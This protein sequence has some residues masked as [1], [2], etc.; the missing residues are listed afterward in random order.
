VRILRLD[1]ADDAAVRA[2]CEVTEA[3]RRADDPFEPPRSAAV[4]HA[5]LGTHWSG[6]PVEAWYV[7]GE[8]DG[9]S[10]WYRADFPDLENLDK[11]F[12]NLVVAP[13]WRCR[14]LG[15]ALLRHAAGRAAASGR[16]VLL[17]EAREGSAGEVFARRA[18]A[19]FGLAGVR[20]VQDL[21]KLPAG[22]IS[23]LRE[24][25][26]QAATGYSMARW[27][28]ITPDK[29]LGQV[30]ALNNALNDAPHDPGVE[31]HIW[32]AQQVRERGDARI[33]APPRR[34]YSL[35]AVHEATGEMA[36]LT[37][38]SVDPGVPG[39]GHQSV[40]MVTQPHRGHRLGLLVKTAMLG[41]LRET[42]PQVERIVTWNAASNKHMIGINED[43][44]YEV[45]GRPYRSAEL[46]VAFVL[47]A[48]S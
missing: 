15:T 38:V 44:G 11:V 13:A 14:G 36:A 34:R 27:T 18:G 23:W 28:G 7:P 31:P 20:R 35:A 47:A 9:A 16:T 21:R 48:Q 42:E 43:L 41:W 6:A 39:W 40:T 3:V 10:A 19:T 12:V 25:A 5:E 8:A 22:T 37:V 26:E 46:P 45:W 24:T 4:F 17:G 32:D 2:C 30:A 1:L 29:W 33:A